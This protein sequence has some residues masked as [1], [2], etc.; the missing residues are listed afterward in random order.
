MSSHWAW[1]IG[2]FEL[3]RE[4]SRGLDAPAIGGVWSRLWIDLNRRADDPTLIRTEAGRVALPWNG[5]LSPADVERRIDGFHAPYHE[6]VDRMIVRLLV[7]GI[8]PLVLA[9]HTFTPRLRGPRRRFDVG[10]LYTDHRGLAHRLGL[11]LRE[12][13]LEVRY[14]QPYSGLKGLMYA[15]ERHGSHHRLPC[16]ELEV[17]QAIVDSPAGVARAARRLHPAL[18]SAMESG[19]A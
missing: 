18:A 12:T 17:N 14:N 1:D 13:G 5:G 4:L 16:L 10:L 8:R 3:T 9:V 19:L 2:A 7:R 6:Q 15:A 11:A